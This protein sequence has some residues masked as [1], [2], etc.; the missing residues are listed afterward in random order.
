MNHDIVKA[1]A[2]Y[3]CT[4]CQWTWASK[5]RTDC[6]GVPRYPYKGA[7][8]NLM[9]RGQL[10][11]LKRKPGTARRG[12]VSNGTNDAY[13]LYDLAESI[14]F[15]FEEIAAKK[16]AQRAYQKSLRERK[17][18]AYQR[19]QMRQAGY[20]NRITR[21]RD[22]AIAWARELIANPGTWVILDTETTGLESDDEIIQIA[23]LAPSGEV[24]MDEMVHPTAEISAE[25]ESVNGVSMAMLAD[26]PDFCAISLQVFE[27]LGSKKIVTYNAD[28]DRRMLAQT[29]ARHNTGRDVYLLDWSDAMIAYSRYYGEWSNYWHDFKWQGLWG[30]D[31]TAKG[32][33]LATLK[34]I[35]DMAT[36]NLSGEKRIG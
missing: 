19:E 25:A 5:P 35:Q 33:C 21:A 10:E 13:D 4:V 22:G 2:G 18:R 31:H 28:F 7:P 12:V 11:K 20:E 26:K 24:L 9:T 15:T 17:E 30:G 29:C 23:I 36:S 27:I 3:R 34:R 32:D 6:P 16:E 14:P 8:A 1:A